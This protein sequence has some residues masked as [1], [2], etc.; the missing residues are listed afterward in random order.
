M[1]V[2]LSFTSLLSWT[3]P[4]CVLSWHLDLTFSWWIICSCEFSFELNSLG[5]CTSFC[6]R[7]LTSI[8]PAVAKCPDRE[9]TQRSLAPKFKEPFSIWRFHASFMRFSLSQ[10]SMRFLSGWHIAFP[11]SEVNHWYTISSTLNMKQ[12]ARVLR[13]MLPA[14]VSHKD[15]YID[16]Q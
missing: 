1:W 9:R 4:H 7:S 6:S 12:D 16:G 10:I 13:I 2:N 8:T 11:I 15:C 5:A 3:Y 14:L